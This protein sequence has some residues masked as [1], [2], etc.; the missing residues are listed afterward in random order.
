[1]HYFR[2][3]GCNTPTQLFIV[4]N[5]LVGVLF[6]K[7]HAIFHDPNGLSTALR[8]P[9]LQIRHRTGAQTT[10]MI[11]FNMR[12][13]ECSIDGMSVKLPSGGYS[14][15][16]YRSRHANL[17]QGSR[18]AA[19]LLSSR[20]EAHFSHTTRVGSLGMI[21]RS[22]GKTTDRPSVARLPSHSHVANSVL[23]LGECQAGEI[24]VAPSDHQR[25]MLNAP[26]A[27]RLLPVE[28]SDLNRPCPALPRRCFVRMA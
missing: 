11:R 13:R 27:R 14:A 17:N 25:R 6:D 8:I 10:R 12:A 19:D 26:V 24:Q 20:Q 15:P 18:G 5:F 16:H 21:S 1:M 3:L 2:L 9:E 23:S 4:V 22:S 28:A 7:N